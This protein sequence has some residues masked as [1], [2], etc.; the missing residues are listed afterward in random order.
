MGSSREAQPGTAAGPDPSSASWGRPSRL[1]PRS[2]PWR[3]KPRARWHQVAQLE[4]GWC[5]RRGWGTPKGTRWGWSLHGAGGS[6]Q[7]SRHGQGRAPWP[8]P[9]GCHTRLERGAIK[10][11]CQPRASGNKFLA[12][13]WGGRGRQE[14]L[15]PW[16][17]SHPSCPPSPQPAITCPHPGSCRGSETGQGHWQPPPHRSRWH[18]RQQETA[19]QPVA[20]A[21]ACCAESGVSPLPAGP[22][23]PREQPPCRGA[24]RRGQGGRRWWCCCW[25]SAPA[26]RQPRAYFN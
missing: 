9:P 8:T 25:F 19:P 14:L 2:T 23:P 17:P 6:A 5:H 4:R 13:C 20:R 26:F 18:R 1:C 21:A 16:Q 22:P 15:C 11:W 3:R 7:Q 12:G 24:G 10:G